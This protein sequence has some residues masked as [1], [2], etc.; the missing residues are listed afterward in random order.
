MFLDGGG[1]GGVG[2]AF[3][4]RRNNCHAQIV[5]EGLIHG[6]TPNHV[7]LLARSILDVI[8]DFRDLIHQDFL[9]TESDVQQDEVRARNVFVIQE[10]RFECLGDGLVCAAFAGSFAGAHDGAAT[11]LH[12]RVDVIHVDVDIAGQGDDLGDA[13]SGGAEDVVGVGE[14]LADGQVAVEFAELVV[15][16]DQQGVDRVADGLESFIGL[17]GAASS[18]ERKWN[19]DDPHRQNVHVSSCLGDDRRG[20]GARAASHA[21]GDEHH[22]CLGAEQCSDVIERFDGRVAADLRARARALA[23]RQGLTEL[24]PGG[25]R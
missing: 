3:K 14:S 5:L 16:D 12:D 19:G 7:G 13:F 9:G 22:F 15:A 1:G 8:R 18:F 24:N 20:S 25:H 23:A 2:L 6:V 21:G 11:V 17:L 4:A 10:R